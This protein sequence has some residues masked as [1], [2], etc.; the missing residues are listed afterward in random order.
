MIARYSSRF[1]D[2]RSF[3]LRQCNAFES[4]C[5]VIYRHSND[6]PVVQMLSGLELDDFAG[7]ARLSLMLA[8]YPDP[9]GWRLYNGD[10]FKSTIF[11]SELK[12]ASIVVSNPPFEAFTSEERSTYDQTHNVQKPAELLYRILQDPPQI[13]GLILPRIFLKGR[14]YAQVRKALFECYGYIK[15]C[16]LPDKVFIQLSEAETVIVLAAHPGVPAR[17]IFYEEVYGEDLPAFYPVRGQ[18]PSDNLRSCQGSLCIQENVRSGSRRDWPYL[19]N[20]PTLASVAEIHRGIEFQ[21][22]FREN[23]EE[24]VSHSPGRASSQA[25]SALTLQSSLIS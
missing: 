18:Q 5:Q 12:K 23:Q 22:P 16:A 11:S 6:T 17:E 9:D 4:C 20:L 19:E 13:L 10:V 14:S 15:L 25:C 21:I 7:V 8:D 24:L 3:L 2:T 1:Q